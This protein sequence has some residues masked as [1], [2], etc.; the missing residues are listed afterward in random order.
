MENDFDLKR[1]TAEF[2]KYLPDKKYKGLKDYEWQNT[3]TR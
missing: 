1:I 2:D 3:E